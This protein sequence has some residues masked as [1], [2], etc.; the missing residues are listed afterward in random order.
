MAWRA[1]GAGGC[2]ATVHTAYITWK[3][4]A[5]GEISVRNAAIAELVVGA[6]ASG[7]VR[8]A[9]KTLGGR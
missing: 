6:A 9:G 8:S 2:T 1:A 3:T 4:S 5:V 7:A